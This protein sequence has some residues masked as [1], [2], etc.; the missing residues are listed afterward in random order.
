MPPTPA[1]ASLI[2]VKDLGSLPTDTIFILCVKAYDLDS[3]LKTLTPHLLTD[4]TLLLCQNGLGIYLQAAEVLGRVRPQ[5]ARLLP[6]FGIK[7]EQDGSLAVSGALHATLSVPDH[8]PWLLNQLTPLLT[9]IGIT[10]SFPKNIAQAEW[11]KAFLNLV[12]NP[13]ACVLDQ[14]NSCVI[15]DESIKKLTLRIA[16]EVRSVAKKEGF[17]LDHINDQ[18]LISRIENCGENINSTLIDFRAGKPSEL[19]Y[20]LGRFLRIAESSG[21]SIDH[22]KTLDIILKSIAPN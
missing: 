12:I 2:E 9:E 4:S 21:I 16:A 7:L 20:F 15:K 14:K 3:A 10:L 18:E 13:L 6:S 8:Q 17:S 22:L 1:G 19:N 11:E 5:I